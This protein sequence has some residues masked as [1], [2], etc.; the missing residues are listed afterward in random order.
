M[1][2]TTKNKQELLDMAA[3]VLYS[4]KNGLAYHTVMTTLA[5]DVN[6]IA[7]RN[8]EGDEFFLPR[9]SGYRKHLKERVDELAA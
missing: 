7:R 8:M 2:M 5:H 1:K 9:S 4:I 6:G 3:F